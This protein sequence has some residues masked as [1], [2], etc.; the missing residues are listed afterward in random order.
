M[1]FQINTFFPAPW[2]Y[3]EVGI[4]LL[5]L[6]GVSTWLGYRSG[7]HRA[8]LW[9]AVLAQLP[10]GVVIFNQ[11]RREL[12]KNDRARP[13]LKELDLGMLERVHQASSQGSFYSAAVHRRD[14]GLIQIEA[15]ALGDKPRGVG[16][17]LRD[18][19][20]EHEQQQRTAVNYQKFIHTLSHELLTPLTTIKVHLG[21]AVGNDNEMGPDRRQVLQVAGTETERLIRLVSNLLILSRLESGHPLQRRLTK[22]NRAAEDAIYQLRE[23]AKT[24]RV[25]LE[26]E[27]DQ[28]LPR[29]QLDDEAWRQLFLNLID[30]GIKYG[31]AGGTVR[32]EIRQQ[33]SGL[34]LTIADDG[35]GI[36]PDDLPHLFEELFRGG[37]S[38]HVGG[39]GLGLAIVRRIVIQHGGQINCT[40]EPGRGATFHITL[41]TEA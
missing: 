11:R 8:P 33:P 13:L 7:C 20:Q 41:P 19:A 37:S 32:V 18:T 40:S 16:L 14:G 27:A 39:S 5:L 36:P 25:S 6:V 23:Q 17:V 21:N 34:Y 24:R 29:L 22:I 1:T 30:N 26:L 15:W 28:D 38:R 2:G 10:L 9:R 4:F 35:P 31:Q 12:F 3:L